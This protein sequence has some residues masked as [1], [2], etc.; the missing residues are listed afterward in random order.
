MALSQRQ[1]NYPKF[2]SGDLEGHNFRSGFF[3][4]PEAIEK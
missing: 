4:P 2:T 3:S 1:Y